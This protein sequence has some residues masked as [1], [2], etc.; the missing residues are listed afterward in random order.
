MA[1]IRKPPGTKVIL[2]DGVQIEQCGDAG[3]MLNASGVVTADLV[4]QG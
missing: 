4:Y 2:R 3:G 1:I